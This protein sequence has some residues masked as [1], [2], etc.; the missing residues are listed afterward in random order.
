MM[1]WVV[2]GEGKMVV[3]V[4]GAMESEEGRRREVE[5]FLKRE[6]GMVGDLNRV[7]VL[8]R[9]DML[10]FCRFLMLKCSSWIS[11]AKFP[12]QQLR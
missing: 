2:E 6:K 1:A 5:G 8:S 12:D 7:E 3:G 11:N 4:V 9:L 10:V